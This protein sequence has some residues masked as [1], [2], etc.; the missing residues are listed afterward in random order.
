MI[1][2]RAQAA[3]SP[4]EDIRNALQ[5]VQLAPLDPSTWPAVRARLQLA[6]HK[7]EQRGAR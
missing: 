2:S 5:L 7:L 4:I 3:E 6:I 1:L